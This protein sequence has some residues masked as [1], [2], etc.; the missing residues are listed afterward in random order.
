M[1]VHDR[2]RTTAE[3]MV[4]CV[5]RTVWGRNA[6]DRFSA[7]EAIHTIIDMA[8]V[9]F[10][11]QWEKIYIDRISLS[12]RRP[13]LRPESRQNNVLAPIIINFGST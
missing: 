1:T 6:D 4:R 9:N 12:Q 13:L 11:V 7:V 2:G 3:V 5:V 10:I 8:G